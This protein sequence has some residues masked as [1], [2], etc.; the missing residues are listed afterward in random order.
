MR[1]AMSSMVVLATVRG[2]SS[3][4]VGL[5]NGCVE[6]KVRRRGKTRWRNKEGRDDGVSEGVT[7]L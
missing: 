3:D 7:K 5:K 1:D 4:F 6:V 2:W